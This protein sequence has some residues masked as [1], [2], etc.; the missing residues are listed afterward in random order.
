MGNGN[1]AYRTVQTQAIG[2]GSWTVGCMQFQWR[3]ELLYHCGRL[4]ASLGRILSHL[5]AL[6]ALWGPA[7]GAF[8][9]VDLQDGSL[10]LLHPQMTVTSSRP[11]LTYRRER[12][13][14]AVADALQP[15]NR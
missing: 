15:L 6:G 14:G 7:A 9:S 13:V 12:V 5:L 10:D 1:I 4:V 2:M 8:Y 11:S 3:L